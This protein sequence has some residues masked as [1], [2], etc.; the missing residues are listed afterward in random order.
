M[1]TITRKSR[2]ISLLEPLVSQ[3]NPVNISVT[4]ASFK[5]FEFIPTLT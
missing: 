2:V 5:I 4:L 1:H 3:P